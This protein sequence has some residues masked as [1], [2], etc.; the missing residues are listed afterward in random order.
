VD[1]LIDLYCFASV[2]QYL[3]W[4]YCS[5][6]DGCTAALS[7]WDMRREPKTEGRKEGKPAPLLEQAAEVATVL[8][9]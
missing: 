4:L 8:R 1:A 9:W 7:C 3:R 2:L 6:C 5:T